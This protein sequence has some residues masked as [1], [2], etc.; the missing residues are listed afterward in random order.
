MDLGKLFSAGR[1]SPH[2]PSGGG[3]IVGVV[4]SPASLAAALALEP[5]PTAPPDALELRADAFANQPETLDELLAAAPRPFLLTVRD[6]AEGGLDP[7][8]ADPDRR[9]AL[10]GRLL[11]TAAAVDIELRNL[12]VP[13]LAVVAE[14]ARA[15]GVPVVA[16]FHDFTGTPSVA[17]LRTR[18]EAARTHGATVF[19][20]ATRVATPADAAQLLALLDR[21]PLPVAAMGMGDAL[22]RATRLVLATA[23]SVLNYGSLDA[24]DGAAAAPGQWPAARLAELVAELSGEW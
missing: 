10:F 11:P 13:A 5:N 4:H 22:A 14:T 12:P 18:A 9:A 6:P 16:S 1:V 21:P 23:G 15:R 19:K 3:G 24:G 2:C 20:V 17:D 7:S 8:L